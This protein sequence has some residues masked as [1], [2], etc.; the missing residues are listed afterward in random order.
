MPARAVTWAAKPLPAFLRSFRW[1]LEFAPRRSPPARQR[2]ALRLVPSPPGCD[3]RAAGPDP[4]IRPPPPRHRPLTL[5]R[6]SRPDL[7]TAPSRSPR[8]G[9]EVRVGDAP[10]G[11]FANAAE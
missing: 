5:A 6:A 3:T 9:W 4:A 2:P 1:P 7:R 11:K 10:P 8:A